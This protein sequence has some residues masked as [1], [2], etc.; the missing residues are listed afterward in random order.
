MV[1]KELLYDKCEQA[2]DL[3]ETLRYIE[4]DD[5]YYQKPLQEMDEN[6]DIT[7]DWLNHMIDNE[8]KLCYN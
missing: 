2:L 8:I 7:I 4:I 6:F 1:D 3:L 5:D